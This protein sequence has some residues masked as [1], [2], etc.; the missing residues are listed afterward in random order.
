[1]MEIYKLSFYQFSQTKITAKLK[2]KTQNNTI[3]TK[4]LQYPLFK[5]LLN[6]D[7]INN[8]ISKKDD[9]NTKE[10]KK[11]PII[12]ENSSKIEDIKKL[13]ISSN[14]SNPIIKLIPKSKDIS[15]SNKG[16]KDDEMQMDSQKA[17]DTAKSQSMSNSLD[18]NNE[19]NT[20]L[21]TESAI[22]NTEKGDI[23]SSKT[24]ETSHQNESSIRNKKN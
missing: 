14:L 11:R 10:S 9:R 15:V 18:K 7:H 4:R 22:I 17:S 23:T 3:W 2:S 1:M 5:N 21:R 19:M 13:K 6:I 12:S 8:S 16:S 24:T 20:S